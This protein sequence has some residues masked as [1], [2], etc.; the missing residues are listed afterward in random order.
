MKVKQKLTRL[1]EVDLDNCKLSNEQWIT[2]LADALTK[3]VKTLETVNRM[4]ESYEKE[5]LLADDETAQ[6][7][8]RIE[9]I[10]KDMALI[11][12][13]IQSECSGA[14]H[15]PSRDVDGNVYADQAWHNVSNIEIACDLDNDESLGWT[16]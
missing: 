9:C 4:S 14:F 1:F 15:Q 12:S 6:L 13:H 2:W 7:K 16:A 8:H 10:K 3:P 11:V 5:R